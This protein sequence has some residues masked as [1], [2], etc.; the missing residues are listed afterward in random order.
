MISYASTASVL[1]DDAAHPLFWRVVSSDIEQSAALADVVD[2]NGDGG[3]IAILLAQDVYTAGIASGFRAALEAKGHTICTEVTYDRT[4]AGS[5]TYQ[6]LVNTVQTDNCG[7]VAVFA[8]NAD[9]AGILEE[10]ATQGFTG[11]V[12]GS[13]GIAS[14]TVADSMGSDKTP[15]H[16]VIATNPEHQIG[17]SD[18]MPTQCRRFPTA[19]VPV[20]LRRRM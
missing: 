16:G 11:Q 3:S 15:I 13:D 17:L 1:S 7:A 10:L 18:Q 4:T 6:D 5:T 19:L 8:Y 2:A 9:G 14:V 12:Y 20:R